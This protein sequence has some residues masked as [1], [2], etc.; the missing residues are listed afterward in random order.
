[1]VDREK[2]IKGLICCS[3]V[4]YTCSDCPYHV[5]DGTGI[6]CKQLEIDALELLK[7][8]RPIKKSDMYFC[9]ECKT[10]LAETW[11]FCPKCGKGAKWND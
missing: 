2:V 7:A 3:T 1:M 6:E 8:K 4:F 11:D 5:P 10:A 9:A